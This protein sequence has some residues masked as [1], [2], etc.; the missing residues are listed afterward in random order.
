M[1]SCSVLAILEIPLVLSE[2]FNGIILLIAGKSPHR[3]H[4]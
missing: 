4:I 3:V 1:Q 2:Q